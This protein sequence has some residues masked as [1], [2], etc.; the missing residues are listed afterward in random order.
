MARAAMVQAGDK[1]RI[2]A[3]KAFLISVGVCEITFENIEEF[4]LPVYD[5]C[6]SFT[7][8]VLTYVLLNTETFACFKPLTSPVALEIAHMR[9][10]VIGIRKDCKGIA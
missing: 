5:K 9:N 7:K 2:N 10:G 3:L 1:L 8:T 6:Y 4:N